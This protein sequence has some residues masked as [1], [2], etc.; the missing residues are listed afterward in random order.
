VNSK[1]GL[2]FFCSNS[3][4]VKNNMATSN[5]RMYTS[6]LAAILSDISDHNDT[7]FTVSEQTSTTN[8]NE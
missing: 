6:V 3:A 7:N 8:T 2:D 5:E 1:S 4:L